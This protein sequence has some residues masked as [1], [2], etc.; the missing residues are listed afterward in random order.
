MTLAGNNIKIK[1]W[2]ILYSDDDAVGG[3]V[4]TGTC[5]GK[6]PARLQANPEEQLLMQQGLETERTFKINIVPGY[7]DIR[8]RDE[9]TVIAP[10][11]HVYYNKWF[12]VRGV[13]YSSLNKRDPRNYMML[14]VSIS[15]R[16]HSDDA[17]LQ[18]GTEI[19]TTTSSLYDRII[20]LNPTIYTPLGDTSSSVLDV[21]GG[22][23][24]INLAESSAGRIKYS[25][26]GCG[27][28]RNSISM[29]TGTVGTTTSSYWSLINPIDKLSVLLWV[30]FNNIFLSGGINYSIITEPW[31]AA[32]SYIAMWHGTVAN[33]IDIRYIGQ[34][35]VTT[36]TK[37]GV[38]YNWHCWA[39]TLDQTLNRFRVYYDGSLVQEAAIL[40]T[41]ASSINPSMYIADTVTANGRLQANL[42]HHAYWS[43]TELT[44][45]QILGVST[46]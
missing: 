2:R 38:D 29:T 44:A 12:R 37:T 1:V 31:T 16:A 32:T 22:V 30:K 20:A 28:G 41:L 46:V 9:I 33:S 21:I 17:V 26:I 14:T 10:T 3:A 18:E 39:W 42:Q 5:I 43:N 11:D 7:L 24:T 25:Q 4:V 13:S 27:D 19:I 36:I 35:S 40:N 45:A 15:V 34:G 8:E 6:Y 23:A